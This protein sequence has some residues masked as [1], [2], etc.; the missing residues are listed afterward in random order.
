MEIPGKRITL[1]TDLRRLH[2]YAQCLLVVRGPVGKRRLTDCLTAALVA[3]ASLDL[4]KLASLS[5]GFS[6]I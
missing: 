4:T 3:P 2:L 1:P 6:F 5:N